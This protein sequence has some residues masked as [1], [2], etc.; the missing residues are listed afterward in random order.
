MTKNKRK[1]YKNNKTRPIDNNQYI[2]FEQQTTIRVQQNQATWRRALILAEDSHFP[3]RYELYNLY[4]DAMIDNHLSGV[5]DLMCEKVLGTDFQLINQSTKKNDDEAT[6]SFNQKWFFDFLKYFLESIYFGHSLIQIDGVTTGKIDSVSLIDRFYVSP[7]LGLI[8]DYPQSLD[9]E[10]YREELDSDYLFEVGGYKNLGLLYK[11]S[12]YMLYKKASIQFWAEYTELFGVPYRIMKTQSQ[13]PDDRQRAEKFLKNMGSSGWGIL[14]STDEY[15][16]KEATKSDANKVY[17]NLI[18]LINSEISKLVLGA[19]E[20]VDGASGGS[21]ARS[22]TH[23][24]QT[25]AKLLS[26]LRDI[27]FY[28]NDNLIP[29]LE[30][31]NVI[32]SGLKFKWNNKEKLLLTDRSEVDAKIAEKMVGILD[33]EYI[34]NTYSVKI[35]DDIYTKDKNDA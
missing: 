30:K 34:E 22:K 24:Q 1:I 27:Q 26:I 16:I 11:I 6:D 10:S 14:N 23:N 8:L 4:Q 21:E 2:K 9:G 19:T 13:L 29:K 25:D 35:S 12:P 31:L 15:E 28:I 5:I 32:K 3:L 20:G 33:T 7:E 18:N 17:E